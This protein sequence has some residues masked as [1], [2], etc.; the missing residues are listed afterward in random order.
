MHPTVLKLPFIGVA[1][2]ERGHASAIEQ[3]SKTSWPLIVSDN[4]LQ[5]AMCQYCTSV[6]PSA[7]NLPAEAQQPLLLVP[8][9]RSLTTV[10]KEGLRSIDL[11]QEGEWFQVVWLL[12]LR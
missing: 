12:Q 9:S 6:Q 3:A 8:A 4:D 7:S 11:G 1:R 2:L 5:Q 10:T